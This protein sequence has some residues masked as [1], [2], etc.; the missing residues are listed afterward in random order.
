M[1]R[2]IIVLSCCCLVTFLFNGKLSVSVGVPIP[3]LK[4]LAIE[5]KE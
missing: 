4:K 2:V 3:S 1:N 5:Q